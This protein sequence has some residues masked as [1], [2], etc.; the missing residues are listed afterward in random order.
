MEARRGRRPSFGLGVALLVA[1]AVLLAAWAAGP[2]SGGARGEPVD[3]STLASYPPTTV[4]GPSVTL[5]GAGDI[6]RCDRDADERTAV[7]LEAQDGFVFTT[8]D[9]AY[10]SGSAT[11]FRECYGPSWGRLR[12]RTFP[13]LGN[14][15]WDT[16]SAAGYLDFFGERAGDRRVGWYAT[17][18]GTWRL[19]V[20][21]S[22]CSQVGGC[23]AASPQGRWLAGELAGHPSACTIAIFHHPLHSTG[24]HG[25]SG[26]VQPFWD[27]LHAAGVELVINGHE[28]SYERFA[29]LDAA[30]EPDPDRGIRQIVVGTGGADLRGFDRADP[31]SEVRDGS[32]H[33]IL[34]LD[35]EAGSFAWRFIPVE[36]GGFTDEGRGTCH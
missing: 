6:A 17:T 14:H 28:H 10:P 12:D 21:V 18:L 23:D 35:L 19:I 22:N 16:G 25:P 7:L 4:S 34:R 2:G 33:G 11:Q 9:N 27:Q 31:R 8:G 13:A 1:V 20:L 36:A 3:I 26:H 32:V 15:D 24:H 29:P 5:A 30:G